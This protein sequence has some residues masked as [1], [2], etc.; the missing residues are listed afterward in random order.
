MAS[1]ACE[2]T[3][4]HKPVWSVGYQVVSSREPTDDEKR[5]G[6]KRV[7]TA[8]RVVE[9]SSVDAAESLG[10]ATLEVDCG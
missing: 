1:A 3:R 7:I 6:A 4:K 9:I 5:R 10:T 8:W 2:S